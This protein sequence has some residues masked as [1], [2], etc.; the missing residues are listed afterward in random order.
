MTDLK[1]SFQKSSYSQ[2]GEDLILKRIFSQLIPLPRGF[3]V[4]V[5][6]FH[7]YKYSNTA[8][9]FQKGWSGVNIDATPGSRELFEIERPNDINLELG[10]SHEPGIAAFQVSELFPSQNSFSMPFLRKTDSMDK[11]TGTEKVKLISLAE[12]LDQHLPENQ[13]IDLLNIDA[14]G[15]DHSVL[16]S[17]NWKRHPVRVVIIEVYLSD[18]DGWNHEPSCTL[19]IGQ[20]F[21]KYAQCVVAKQ[22]FSIIFINEGS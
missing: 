8:L 3:Y 21:K 12:V 13:V 15:F 6:A 5:G 18:P 22:V 17:H 20:G 11:I 19:L 1:K 14:E 7:P 10:I 4:D 16:L 2:A 9:L